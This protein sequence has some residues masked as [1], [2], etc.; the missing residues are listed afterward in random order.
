[1]ASAEFWKGKR[2]LL[3]GHT[4]FKGSWLQLWLTRLGADVRGLSLPAE[5]DPS[6]HVLL[7]GREADGETICDIRDKVAVDARVTQ[8]KPQIAFHLAA[9]P[10]V[11]AGYRDP[12]ATFE[13]NV[14]GT[15]H[16]LDALRV[17]PDL[18]AVVVVTTDKVYEN[19]ENGRPFIETDPLGG[20]DPYSASKAAAEIVT[21]SYRASFF[22]ARRI[23]IATARAGN[24][25]GGGDWAE[26]RLIPDAV[27]AWSS[28]QALSVRRPDAVRPWQ[29]VLEPLH[30]YMLMAERLW[31][32][33]DFAASLNFG[34][35]AAAA[36]TVGAVLE[37]ARASY[38][39][40]EMV[41]GD[42]TEGPHEAGYLMLD[43]TRAERLL[44][45]R[46]TWSF[47]ETIERTMGWYRELAQ[48]RP[49][50]ELCLADI[51]AFETRQRK[52][53]RLAG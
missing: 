1:M 4:G 36:A 32:E 48:G 18:R 7:N 45:Y 51:T 42:G 49:A 8:F 14:Q 13:T 16:L 46:P 25:I 38:G 22:A 41:L 35:N 24:V 15:A 31:S 12:A 37:A 27:R 17:S 26:D 44:G 52:M 43:S 2:V 6:L 19:P 3:T 47:T 39:R 33:P 50:Q 28:Y 10:L 30:G 20:H 53:E 29:H 5:T 21:A 9:Q 34:P 40:G 11:R 23:G